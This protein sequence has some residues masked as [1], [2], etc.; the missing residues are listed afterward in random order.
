MP[1]LKLET[2][3]APHGMQKNPTD[4]SPN[5]LHSATLDQIRTLVDSY[6]VEAL[7]LEG[8]G[9]MLLMEIGPKIFCSDCTGMQGVPKNCSTF[10]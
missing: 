3:T 2:I 8:G 5:Q 10:D 4:P 1:T 9:I 7:T 6:P